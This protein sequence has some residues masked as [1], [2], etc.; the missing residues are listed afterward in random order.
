MANHSL[1]AGSTLNDIA[2]TILDDEGQV[3]VSVMVDDGE[4]RRAQLYLA[5]FID[6]RFEGGLLTAEDTRRLYEKLQVSPAEM[7]RIRN[8]RAQQLG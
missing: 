4:L 8:F 7:E 1:P 2:L 5:G 6:A 3:K